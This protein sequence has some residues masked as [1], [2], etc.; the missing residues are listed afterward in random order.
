[1]IEVLPEKPRQRAPSQRSL[2]TRLRIFDAAERLFAERGFDGASV[3]DIAQAAGV[4]APLV[5]HHGHSKEALF[6]AV[7]ARRADE[8][9]AL[10]ISALD[11][12]VAGG[13]PSLRQVLACF[14]LPLFDKVRDGGPE[15]MAY[16][17]LIAHVSADERWRPVAEACFDPTAN[18]FVDTIATLLPGVERARIAA[19]F[20]FMV[21]AS[22]SV[23][24]SGWRVAALSGTDPARDLVAGLVD[25]SAAGF[26][27]LQP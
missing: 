17:R 22:L 10:R 7:V 25:F 5:I 15:W 9:A 6:F 24:T 18:R 14:V 3:R 27:A 2:D 23:F 19:S 21:A 13:K 26:E 12:L 4:Q 1:M 16:G 20:V 8:L 11:R